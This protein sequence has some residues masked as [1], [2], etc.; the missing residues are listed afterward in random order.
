ME[1]LKVPSEARIREAPRGWGLGRVAIAP[2][3]YGGLGLC[4]RKIFKKINVEIAYFS[5]FLQAKTVSSA[6]T[7]RIMGTTK[8]FN[9]NVILCII[10]ITLLNV[11]QFS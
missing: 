11:K 4:P 7:A 6:V 5:A 2:P 10:A 9:K 1:G 3:Q 8:W